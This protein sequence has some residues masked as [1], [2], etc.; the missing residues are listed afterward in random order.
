MGFDSALKKRAARIHHI[1]WSSVEPPLI[2]L[3]QYVVAALAHHNT[4]G[5]EPDLL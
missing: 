1:E 3:D 5:P 4:S 2:E